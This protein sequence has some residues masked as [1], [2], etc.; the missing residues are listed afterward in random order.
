MLKLNEQNFNFYIVRE[1]C[2]KSRLDHHHLISHE[3]FSNKKYASS[4]IKFYRKTNQFVSIS[5]TKFLAARQTIK[6]ICSG[7]E[8]LENFH[9]PN[10]CNIVGKN[11]F[12]AEYTNNLGL[13]LLILT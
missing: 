4:K 9:T 1:H 7:F 5:T 8:K 12:F 10:N 13:T 2:E 3:K 6:K 11:Y